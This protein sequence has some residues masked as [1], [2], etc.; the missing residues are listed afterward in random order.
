MTQ[1]NVD[2]KSQVVAATDIVELIGRSV[3]LKRRGKDYLGLCPFHQ[4]KSPSFSV[5]PAK[6][7]FYCYG[8]KAGGDAFK[9]VMMRDRVEFIDALKLLAEQANIE[10]PRYGGAKEKTGERQLLLDAHSQACS[11]FEKLLAHPEQGR[12]AREYLE[13]RGIDAASVGRFQIGYAPDAWDG[14]LRGDVGRRFRPPLLALAGLAK[15]RENGGGHYDTFRNRLMFPIRDEQNRIIAFGG[16]VMPGSKDP[17]KYLNSPETPLFSKSRCIFGIDLARQKIVET[18][19]VVVV[20]GYT[21]VVM[22]HQHGVTN[23]VS[24]LGTA[25]TEQHVG[26]LRRFADRIVLLFDADFAGDNAVDKAVGLFLTQPIAIHIASMPPDTD[27][28]E[29][30]LKNGAEEFQRVMAEAPDAL[31]YKWRQ[32]DRRFAASEGDL[33]GQQKAVET[34]LETLAGARGS[35]PVDSIRWGGALTRVSRLTGIPVDDLTKRFRM[36]PPARPAARPAAGAAHNEAAPAAAPRALRSWMPSGQGQAERWILGVLL[37][38]PNRWARVQRTV[39]VADFADA[40]YRRLAEIY[41]E[42]QRHEGNRYLTSSSAYCRIPCSSS[43][44]SRSSTRSRRCPA[45]TSAP[46]R[47]GPR[48]STR[49]LR[50]PAAVEGRT[51][52]RRAT[53]RQRR[54]PA[55]RAGRGGPAQATSG[56]GPPARPE[57][58]VGRWPRPVAPVPPVAFN[59]AKRTQTGPCDVTGRAF[60]LALWR[61]NTNRS[62]WRWIER[63]RSGEKCKTKP[64]AARTIQRSRC[65]AQIVRDVGHGRRSKCK[66]SQPAKRRGGR[67]SGGVT[68]PV[69]CKTNPPRGI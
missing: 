57:A 12:A 23:V 65:R 67:G 56:K 68:P 64:T 66:R 36:Q 9:F 50:W 51:E 43:W 35:G 39:G 42:H 49:L 46:E 37:L 1:S 11:F 19:T 13:T 48:R 60:P 59:S 15:V 29:F 58:A 10:L 25:L 30:L 8:C 63:S 44:P 20:E 7:M 27:P 69:K 32:L 6:Q 47:P 31:T 14:L 53:P 33:T 28:D 3:A 41:W 22:A 34:Y 26:I 52:T 2:V 17:A 18:R 62:P 38:E 45:Q 55:R 61:T 4:E 5:S 21:D 24:I 16:R 54:G 40:E